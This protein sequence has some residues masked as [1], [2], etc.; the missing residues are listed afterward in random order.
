MIKQL[1]EELRTTTLAQAT[2][3]LSGAAMGVTAVWM[4]AGPIVR[5]FVS[6]AIAK[7]MADQGV[8]PSD[9]IATQKHI[10]EIDNNVDAIKSEVDKARQDRV[11]AL[12]N[13]ELIKVQN[14]SMAR[15]VDKL[16]RMVDKL[17]NIQLRQQGQI[18]THTLVAT[19]AK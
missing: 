16:E 7:I 2:R 18:E 8:K 10:I 17:L 5:P 15:S 19:E 13:Q 11:V 3:M 9:F 6:E 1:L 4:F 14:I 12:N